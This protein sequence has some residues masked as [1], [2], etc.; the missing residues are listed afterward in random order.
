MLMGAGRK[1][2]PLSCEPF[3]GERSPHVGFQRHTPPNPAP[4]KAPR[5]SPSLAG[6]TL[7]HSPDESEQEARRRRQ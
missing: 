6:I 7:A 3:L 4:H 5:N 2:W 1:G